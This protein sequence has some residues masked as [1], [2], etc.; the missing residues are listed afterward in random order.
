MRWWRNPSL[1]S[2]QI[3]TPAHHGYG[4]IDVDR[5]WGCE[6]VWNDLRD[7]DDDD[8]GGDDDDN[9]RISRCTTQSPR[10]RHYNDLR[11][12]WLGAA[13]V[14]RYMWRS[15]IQHRHAW[16]PGHRVLGNG[17]GQQQDHQLHR[18]RTTQRTAVSVPSEVE[19]R[20]RIQRV[21]GGTWCS[22][23]AEGARYLHIFYQRKSSNHAFIL[24]QHFLFHQL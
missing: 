16:G 9:A 7:T 11:V 18:R 12:D 13:R 8:G 1:C 17:E 24:F 20:R 15:A 23:P 21:C 2:W 3:Y 14:R 19:E 22:C 10:H 5:C 6:G 4:L